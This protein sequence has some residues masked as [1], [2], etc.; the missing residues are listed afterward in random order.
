MNAQAVNMMMRVV[1]GSNAVLAR[2]SWDPPPCG[3]ELSRFSSIKRSTKALERR[4]SGLRCQYGCILFSRVSVKL[5]N[6]QLSERSLVWSVN[7]DPEC[8]SGTKVL[9]RLMCPSCRL[10]D[11]TLTVCRCRLQGTARIG[12]CDVLEFLRRLTS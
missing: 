2:S 1:V 3:D 11:E 8:R 10:L 4:E 6:A 9:S 7:L 12:G 5:G